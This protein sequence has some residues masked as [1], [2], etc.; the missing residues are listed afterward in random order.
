MEWAA[1][2]PQVPN[3]YHNEGEVKQ[4]LSLAH[5][6]LYRLTGDQKWHDA[7]KESLKESYPNGINGVKTLEG[8]GPWAVAEYALLPKE[9][10]D[11][12]LQSQCR[13]IVLAT[14][15]AKVAD[16]TKWAYGLAP[17][18]Y[19]WDERLGTS[20]E[21]VTAH[22][23]TGDAKY[24]TTMERAAQFGLGL[25]P[26]N[27]SYTTG[28]GSRQVVPFHLDARNLGV[29]YPEGITT[30]G[31][32][33]RNVWRGS[34]TEKRMDAAGLYPAWEDWPW[35][36]SNFNI[37]EPVLTEHV[38]GGNMANVLLT[39]A[40]LAQALSGTPLNESAKRVQK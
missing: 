21:L 13:R 11:A 35:A 12:A 33:P 32:S 3:I 39:R 1:K 6:W 19:N 9:K 37:R 17:Q 28:I 7:F 22:R 29:R 20:W 34:V 2:N 10:A 15:D 16:T 40:Y 26:S 18:R 38:V 14:A 27:T 24:L 23:L 36:E 30:I 5:I 31:P 8:N 4:N 25:N